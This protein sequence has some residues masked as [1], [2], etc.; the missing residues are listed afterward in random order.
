[1]VDSLD[2]SFSSGLRLYRL[3]HLVVLVTAQLGSSR[4]CLG[5]MDVKPVFE[6]TESA[7]RGVGASQLLKLTMYV[8]WRASQ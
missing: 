3:T 5:T 7:L 2:E 4:G 8:K 6:S 1:M